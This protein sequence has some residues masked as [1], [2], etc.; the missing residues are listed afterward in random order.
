MPNVQKDD[1]GTIVELT[2]Q[3]NGTAV[4]LSSATTL[5]IIFRKTDGT[6]VTKTAS[7]STDGTD[8]K[9]RYQSVAGDFNVAG[10]WRVQARVVMGGKDLKSSVAEFSVLENL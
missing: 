4:D 9:I 6:T 7:F 1:I 10:P 5:Q 8:G 3:E 2:L